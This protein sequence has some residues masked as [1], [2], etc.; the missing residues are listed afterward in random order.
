MLKPYS[1]KSNSKYRDISRLSLSLS[2]H[3]FIPINC[4]AKTISH[5]SRTRCSI[6]FVCVC[7]LSSLLFTGW[8]TT[9]FLPL[10]SLNE[11]ICNWFENKCRFNVFQLSQFFF[12]IWN[13]TMAYTKHKLIKRKIE[14][15]IYSYWSRSSSLP[16]CVC[17]LIFRILGAW[18]CVIE[19]VNVWIEI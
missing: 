19:C 12:V 10:F 17:G 13:N 1:I 15:D 11:R 8:I 6:L 14:W 4:Q 7:V 3:Y 9:M 2:S 18:A 16:V 5:G